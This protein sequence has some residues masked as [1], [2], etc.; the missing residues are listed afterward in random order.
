MTTATSI[1]DAA[2]ALRDQLVG[3]RR[4]FH[5]HPELGFQEVETAAYVAG[6]LRA[7][8]I[9][10]RTGV[11]GTGVVGLIRGSREGRTVLLRA[12][13]D[14]L[15]RTG[16]TG[17]EYACERPGVHHACGHDGHTAILLGV[18]AVLVQ[19]RDE[20]EGAVKLVFQPAEEGP[21]G[22]RPMIEAGI[23]EGR[24][25]VAGFGLPPSTG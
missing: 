17:A 19:R 7:L 25:A 16:E 6:R 9:E 22:A 18:A 5:R 14:A 13:M 15:P 4:H 23:M 2:A 8:G 12:G 10:T 1:T 3:D 11:A 21:G 24:H 20:I